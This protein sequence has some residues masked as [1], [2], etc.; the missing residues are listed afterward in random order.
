VS[1]YNPDWLKREIGTQIPL[2]IYVWRS[3][4][5]SFLR[6]YIRPNLGGEWFLGQLFRLEDRF[7]HFMGE[8]GQYPMIVLKKDLK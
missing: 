6:A 3:V 2:E 1:K 8:H 5:V 7:P 4:S